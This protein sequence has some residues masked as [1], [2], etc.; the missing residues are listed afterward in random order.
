MLEPRSGLLL[1]KPGKTVPRQ[2]ALPKGNIPAGGL[3][4]VAEPIP[5]VRVIAG[6]LFSE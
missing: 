1:G 4:T 5:I 3:T 6:C 2:R